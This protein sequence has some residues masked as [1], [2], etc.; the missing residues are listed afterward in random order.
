MDML[1]FEHPLDE[2][3]RLSLRL[4]FIVSNFNY[5]IHQDDQ[6]SERICIETIVNISHL[7]D[8]PD[9]K[10]KYARELS[11]HIF[12]L[13][14]LT[15]KSELNLEHLRST[16]A[17]LKEYFSYFSRPGK[18]GLNLRENFF[19]NTIRQHLLYPGGEA[20]FELPAYYCW[21]NSS[22]HEKISSL[23]KWFNEFL[24]IIEAVNLLLKLTRSKA[25][26]KQ[27]MALSGFHHEP[28]DT[29]STPK[30]IQIK[31]NHADQAYPSISAGRHRI[32][33][34]FNEG[35]HLIS[36]EQALRDINFELVLCF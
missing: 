3:T 33:I 18:L 30:L 26:S 10:S 4:E 9:L 22:R 7:L 27:L 1:L 32:N 11:A 20:D 12:Q 8:R 15:N 2:L 28:L 17:D 23:T 16:I 21:L 25:R 14:H 36:E 34:R 35:R 5:Y 6:R 13:E 24:P 29:K 31:L 19:L